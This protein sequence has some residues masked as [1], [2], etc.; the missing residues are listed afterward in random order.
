M[1]WS[2]DGTAERW[3][4]AAA[5]A[6]RTT[7][8]KPT[9][10]CA[11]RSAATTCSATRSSSLA[12]HPHAPTTPSWYHAG[13]TGRDREPHPSGITQGTTGHD[14]EPRPA[15]NQGAQNVR[16]AQRALVPRPAPR[17]FSTTSRRTT[18][19]TTGF[20]MT[21]PE[22][23]AFRTPDSPHPRTKGEWQSRCHGCRTVWCSA[24]ASA[25]QEVC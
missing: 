15:H 2:V 13:R 3:S 14:R 17:A 20:G 5:S 8:K 21:E 25:P 11:K 12:R 22:E 19:C 7:V 6:S 23:R 16:A 24:A 4:S 9:I 10:S 18:P 1:S